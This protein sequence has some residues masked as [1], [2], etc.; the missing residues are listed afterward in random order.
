VPKR[1]PTKILPPAEY[2]RARLDYNPETGELR[3]RDGPRARKPAGTSISKGYYTIGIFGDNYQAHRVIWKWMT[4]EEPPPSI[5]HKENGGLD[6]RWDNLRALT[7]LQQQH[8]RRWITPNATGRRGV[9]PSPPNRWIAR[10]RINH[11]RVY[12]GCFTTIEAAAAAYEAAA[13]KAREEIFK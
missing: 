7:P 6:N 2:L 1:Q 8:N 4:G 10:I 3:W 12:L 9:Y 11:T 5:D 13:Q